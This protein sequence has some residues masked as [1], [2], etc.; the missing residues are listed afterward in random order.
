MN[1]K[2]IHTYEDLLEYKSDLQKQ[3]FLQKQ[4]IYEDVHQIKEELKPVS[5][6]AK[7]IGRFFAPSEDHSWIVRGTNTMVDLLVRN[8]FL[9]K[10]GW[11]AR[12]VV[13]FLA[14]N[15]SS[16]LVSDNKNGLLQKVFSW[17][18]KDRKTRKQD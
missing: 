4:L 14:Q 10:S 2:P 6:I 16:H 9:K 1:K 18:S 11:L 7:K 17:F 15:I 8:V 3:L 5:E 12:A 13:P